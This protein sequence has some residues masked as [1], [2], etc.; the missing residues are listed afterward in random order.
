MNPARALAAL[1]AALAAL[2]PA[3][4]GDSAPQTSA[5]QPRVEGQTII[6][7]PESPQI[8]SLAVAAIEPWRESVL[9]F[10]GR[11]VWDEDRTVRV[12]S[13]LGGRVV[14]VGVRA[15]D[16]VRAGQ[17]LAVIASPELGAAQAEARKAKVDED[18]ARTNLA[19]IEE[20]HAAG[21]A[22]AKDLLAARTE[23]ARAAAERE[24]QMARL[25]LYGAAAATVDQRFALAAPIA[26]VVVERNLNPGQELRADAQPEKGLFVISDPGRLWFL[27]DIAE[28][29]VGAVRVGAEV[30]LRATL[31]GDRTL[32]GRITAI[33]DF[34]DPQTRTVKVRGAVENRERR[35][36]AEMFVTAELRV[37]AA[38]GLLVPARA[39][40]LRGEQHY[41]FVERGEG[42]F[43]RRRVRLGPTIDAHQVVLEGVALHERVV[44]DGNLLLERL[45]AAKD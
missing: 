21:V 13:P 29:D 35:A 33:A 45:L 6:F 41:V 28:A 27:L 32:A 1:W 9:R 38:G 3:A 42:R 24:R 10:P 19:R 7:A 26:G 4:C 5:P 23:A 44:V 34:V 30:Q 39:V 11:L 14:A 8:A 15:G 43:E 36:K 25:R 31:L 18:L 2:G 37:P 40:Y 22:P 17:T 16:A 20:L 12:F